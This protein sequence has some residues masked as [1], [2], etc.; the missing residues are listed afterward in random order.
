M[1]RASVVHGTLGTGTEWKGGTL[2]IEMLFVRQSGLVFA[3][4]IIP[5]DVTL[6]VTRRV[7]SPLK[8][9]LG[10]AGLYQQHNPNG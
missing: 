7:T 3:L 5:L 9:S 8:R 10:A 4:H 6:A 1:Q 2:T